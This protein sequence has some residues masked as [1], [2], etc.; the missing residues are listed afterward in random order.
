MTDRVECYSGFQY[1]D[2]PR[3]VQWQGQL[4]EIIEIQAEWRTPVSRCFRVITR[5]GL[6]LDLSYT[7]MNDEWTIHPV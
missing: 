1:A 4:L 3:A 5:A 6:C 7:E 2:K